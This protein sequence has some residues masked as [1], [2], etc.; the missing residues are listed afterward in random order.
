MSGG[1]RQS[2]VDRNSGSP[3]GGLGDQTMISRHSG[4]RA[5]S[6][7]AE[8]EWT[9]PVD[10]IVFPQQGW[11]SL[12][13]TGLKS[14]RFLRHLLHI[15]GLFVVAR[16]QRGENPDFCH[17][18]TRLSDC[19]QSIERSGSLEARRDHRRICS[20]S[21]AKRRRGIRSLGYV[22]SEGCERFGRP[23]VVAI[24]G[25]MK[26]DVADEQGDTIGR[27]HPNQ[28]GTVVSSPQN[29]FS[30]DFRICRG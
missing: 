2:V 24:E 15:H 13:K 16:Q 4:A 9:S 25:Y 17:R 26:D 19:G 22:G 20:K 11:R 10:W 27:P 3:R 8:S 1:R 18:S 14:Q 5:A 6:P 28:K 7:A 12:T 23:D 21:Y 29:V 30:Q